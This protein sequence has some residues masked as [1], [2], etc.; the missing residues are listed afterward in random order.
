RSARTGRRPR[1]L[2]STVRDPMS[3]ATGPSG[4]ASDRLG[5]EDENP[6]E[7]GNDGTALFGGEVEV[8]DFR[9]PARISKDRMR[10]LQAMYEVLA[11]SL[12]SWTAGRMRDHVAVELQSMEQITFGEF[13]HAL[14]SPCASYI[15]DLAGT[16]RQGVIDFGHE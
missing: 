15:V 11:K 8:Y 4:G 2:C 9:R 14:P 13:Q 7:R 5:R 6:E 16:G 1:C 12:E 10:P 3:T